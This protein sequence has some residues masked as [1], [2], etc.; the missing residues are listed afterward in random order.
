[1][2]QNWLV[3][4]SPERG[5]R[6]TRS[7]IVYHGSC[8]TCCCCLHTAGALVG[9][10]VGGGLRRQPDDPGFDPDHRIP[11][12]HWLFDRLPRTQW[13]F[14]SNL[15][16]ILV[17]SVPVTAFFVG[18]QRPQE[19]P[20]TAAAAFVLAGP[21]YLLAAWLISLV[22]LVRWSRQPATHA[23]YWALHKTLAW[24]LAGTVG[25]LLGIW[26]IW[27]SMHGLS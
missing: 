20:L 1:M 2:S 10:F 7:T 27:A 9:A 6:V 26:L 8:C 18:L 17:M 21:V 22:R 11:G 14:W 3:R 25:G 4:H 24:A 5:R 12:L 19:I 23:E 16:L 13:V 15:L